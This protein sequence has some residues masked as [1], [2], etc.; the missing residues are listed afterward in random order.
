M[1]ITFVQNDEEAAAA[2]AGILRGTWIFP[3]GL[4]DDG[5]FTVVDRQTSAPAVR[6]DFD[7]VDGALLYALGIRSEGNPVR[8]WDRE[9]ALKDWGN[10]V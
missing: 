3:P 4:S 1:K 7:T 2:R 9:G 5:K 6:E 8:D 10:F